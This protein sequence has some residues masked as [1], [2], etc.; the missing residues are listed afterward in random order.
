VETLN[1]PIKQQSENIT[2]GGKRQKNRQNQDRQQFSEGEICSTH[3]LR[4]EL[5]LN[6]WIEFRT[7]DF[8]ACDGAMVIATNGL[9]PL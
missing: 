8:C 6:T 2:F 4:R 3:S 1:D 7:C 9:R 5:R